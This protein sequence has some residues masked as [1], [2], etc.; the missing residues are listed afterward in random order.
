M[1]PLLNPWRIQL[2]GDQL[3]AALALGGLRPTAWAGLPDAPPP[4]N[5]AATLEGLGITTAG[6]LTPEAHLALDA[7]S[8]PERMLSVIVNNAGSPT[9]A[10]W[11]IGSRSDGPYVA[12]NGGPG[13]VDMS[14]VPTATQATILIDDLLGVTALVARSSGSAWSLDLP[15]YAALLA[16]ADALQ[17]ARLA[18][19]LARSR[20]PEP[21][22]TN[23]E[24][25]RQLDAGLASADSR[26]AV[27][28]ARLIAPLP[29]STAAGQLEAGCAD[30]AA[31]GLLVR[32][33]P[34]YRL[35]LTGYALADSL[36]QLVT[37][38]GLRLSLVREERWQSVC[39]FN[40]FRTATAI[41]VAAWV[42]AT[43]D[44]TEVRLQELSATG[45]LSLV[46]DLLQPPDV[47]GAGAATVR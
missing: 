17:A 20:V 15:G 8:S 5:A 1:S 18:A 36:G 37:T 46:R 6:A 31:K 13:A 33:G 11:L 26:W 19:R 35:S 10:E 27:T 2:S 39:Q 41:W 28:A 44:R 4:A 45:T 24:L 42:A 14:V 7:L 38:A 12:R 30:L 34:G 22:L 40:L 29:L 23:A 32:S 25:G 9:W 47:F 3:A 21:E 16:A 43:P